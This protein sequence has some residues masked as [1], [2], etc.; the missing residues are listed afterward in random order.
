MNVC[1]MM[2]PTGIS[3]GTSI[4]DPHFISTSLVNALDEFNSK[5]DESDAELMEICKIYN[6][7]EYVFS[8]ITDCSV[9]RIEAPS[10]LYYE[11]HEIVSSFGMLKTPPTSVLHI[12]ATESNNNHSYYDI[13][14]KFPTLSLLFNKPDDGQQP[15][16]Q[17]QQQQEGQQ[18]QQQQQQCQ[19]QES[20]DF[21]FIDYTDLTTID[22]QPIYNKLN[23]SGSCIIKLSN[24]TNKRVI[25][26]IYVLS[27]M[28]E[29]THLLKPSVMNILSGDAFIMCT[30]FLN[31][32]TAEYY[33]SI[34]L[35]TI[36]IPSIFL[37]RIEEFNS[38]NGHRQLD[39]YDQVF[40]LFHNKN[41]ISKLEL[42]K[43]TNIQKS[44][45]WCDKHGIPHNKFG[46]R[47]NMFLQ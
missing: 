1:I 46:D 15:W 37:C 35:S 24:I 18:Q 33:G 7:H 32:T 19:Q 14:T 47:I 2:K 34:D 23:S 43:K 31:S 45:A 3:V 44:V 17:P 30:S 21:M 12:V 4:E 38:I 42:L 25:S 16:G 13:T 20:V 8:V 11:L 27:I 26:A 40:N 10:N 22:I 41:K 39:A 5:M 36:L 29:K 9:S 28:F 6:P